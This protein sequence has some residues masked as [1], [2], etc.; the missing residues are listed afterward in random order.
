MKNKLPWM[1]SGFMAIASSSAFASLIGDT[2]FASVSNA[3]YDFPS[4]SAVVGSG[5]E[6]SLVFTNTTTEVD[7]CA[8][9]VTLSYA[10]TSD[11]PNVTYP[12]LEYAFTDLDWIGDPVT[13]AGWNPTAVFRSSD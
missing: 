4:N 13:I 1:L 5:P 3:V 6:F 12:V 2:V 8:D 10:N 11:F 7:F 9:S